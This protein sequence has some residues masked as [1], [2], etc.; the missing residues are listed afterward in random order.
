MLKD[1]GYYS[2]DALS[3]FVKR[4]I[5][6]FF[7]FLSGVIFYRSVFSDGLSFLNLA[8]ARAFFGVGFFYIIALTASCGSIM[9]GWRARYQKHLMVCSA[10][11]GFVILMLAGGIVS[12]LFKYKFLTSGIAGFAF[13]KYLFSF[14]QLPNSLM[15]SAKAVMVLFLFPLG[16]FFILVSLN[17]NFENVLEI[18]SFIKKCFGWFAYVIKIPLTILSGR[19]N[20]AIPPILRSVENASLRPVIILWA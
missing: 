7:L 11:L 19:G 5:G 13:E 9:L 17:L 10:L 8:G 15:V 2:D 18:F 6:V 14:F 4:I 20:P 16:L 12:S 1:T 3:V